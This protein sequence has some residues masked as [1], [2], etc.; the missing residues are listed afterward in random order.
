MPMPIK[1]ALTSALSMKVPPAGEIAHHPP[2]Y[3]ELPGT[4]QLLPPRGAAG[5]RLHGCSRPSHVHGVAMLRALCARA[6]RHCGCPQP[7]GNH[8]GAA[9]HAAGRRGGWRPA[10]QGGGTHGE[11]A[12]EGPVQVRGTSGSAPGARD[13]RGKGGR[14]NER[15][16]SLARHT[17][18][19]CVAE[20]LAHAESALPGPAD[21]GCVLHERGWVAWPSRCWCLACRRTWVGAP[22]LDSISQNPLEMTTLPTIKRKKVGRS[23]R[24]RSPAAAIPGEAG[25]ETPWGGGKGL[26]AAAQAAAT[27]V[28]AVSS[29]RLAVGA[30]GGGAEQLR[31]AAGTVCRARS[32]I[33]TPWTCPASWA[34]SPPTETSTRVSVCWVHPRLLGACAFGGCI[35]AR[36]RMPPLLLPLAGCATCPLMCRASACPPAAESDEETQPDSE[37]PGSADAVMDRN[38]IKMRAAKLT[39]R[40]NAKAAQQAQ[41]RM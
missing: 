19:W 27:G 31:R 39:A 40:H 16:N 25:L 9:A 22:W 1:R 38:Y 4:C 30:G 35:A 37:A 21:G 24:Q 2:E 3:D 26:V 28:H 8:G 15:S 34:T 32:A 20:R 7:G 13:R 41:A 23:G 29:A 33:P 17:D 11:A 12:H 10:Q 18:A 6:C 14:G 36:R 5:L